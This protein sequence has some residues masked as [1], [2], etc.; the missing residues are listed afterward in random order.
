MRHAKGHVRRAFD[1][2]A[3]QRQCATACVI[4][5]PVSHSAICP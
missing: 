5:A 3:V 4:A 2:T 1:R